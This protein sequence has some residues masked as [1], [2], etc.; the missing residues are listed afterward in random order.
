[1][2]NR[3]GIP[4]AMAASIAR[5]IRAMPSGSQPQGIFSHLAMSEEPDAR[6]S[7]VQRERFAALRAELAPAAPAAHFHLGNSGA[8]W[9]RKHWGLD[10]LTD[11]VRPG[12]SLYGVP[13]WAG[14]PARG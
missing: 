8:V 5:A 6:L 12:L 4:A 3:L 2:M 10:G 9:N 14:A 7:A 11:V 1:G 13:H